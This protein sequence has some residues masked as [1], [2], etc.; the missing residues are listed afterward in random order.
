VDEWLANGVNIILPQQGNITD[1]VT[2]GRFPPPTDDSI[3]RVVRKI[4]GTD[5]NCAVLFRGHPILDGSTGLVETPNDLPI[6]EVSSGIVTLSR[7]TIRIAAAEGLQ[8]KRTIRV[9]PESHD[10]VVV[11]IYGERKTTFVKVLSQTVRPGEVRELTHWVPPGQLDH[12]F[13]RIHPGPK[14]DERSD[15]LVWEL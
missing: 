8:L 1:V 13:I 14:F 10:G 3:C 2:T 7:T 12:I 4:T 5:R 9:V 15:W 6:F 11:E